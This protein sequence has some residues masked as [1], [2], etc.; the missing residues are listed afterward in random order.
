MVSG[1]GFTIGA[2][3][4]AL[5]LFSGAPQGALLLILSSA[6]LDFEI[7][8]NSKSTVAF[9][10]VFSIKCPVNEQ[11]L[12]SIASSSI[13]YCLDGFMFKIPVYYFEISPSQIYESYHTLINITGNTEYFVDSLPNCIVFYVDVNFYPSGQNPST[14]NVMFGEL[15]AFLYKGD[16]LV[17]ENTYTENGHQ[18]T[19]SIPSPVILNNGIGTY[20]LIVEYG[21]GENG[22]ITT[23]PSYVCTY[24]RVLVPMP[25]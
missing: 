5:G 16:N 12:V 22:T 15:T 20:E 9:T 11:F 7:A 24:F 23:S 19:I 18:L 3:A 21:G 4:L 14:L 8:Q 10:N 25:R 6:G 13:S 2:V 1:F 17:W